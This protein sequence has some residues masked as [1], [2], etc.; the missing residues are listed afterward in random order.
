MH[1]RLEHHLTRAVV[2]VAYP[3]AW[4]EN[5]KVFSGNTKFIL[6]YIIGEPSNVGL[7]LHYLY[8][9][10]DYVPRGGAVKSCY[11]RQGIAK[12][13][14]E[15]MMKDYDADHVVFTVWG[16][17][18]VASWELMER[19]VKGDLA[20]KFTYNPEL[21]MS[22]LLPQGW[23]QGI[24]ATLNPDMAKALHK[25]KMYVPTAF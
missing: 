18:L 17:E 13:L 6:G 2:R 3:E 11:R 19:V 20:H 22:T 24:P 21:F 7:I 8:T 14:L 4:E 9:R 25:T 10:R 16:Q 12:K 5:G 15:G 1:R 23:E